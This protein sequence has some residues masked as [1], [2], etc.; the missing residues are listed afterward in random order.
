[1][2]VGNL[3]YVAGWY[4]KA[5]QFINQSKIKCAFVS[6]NSITQGQQVP[7]LWKYLMEEHNIVINFAYRTFNWNSEAKDKAAVHCVI[8]GFSQMNNRNKKIYVSDEQIELVN[9]INGYLIDSKNIF[10]S[11]R[12]TPI[13][14]IP[15]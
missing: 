9:N 2:G 11:S 15:K 3:D 6:T 12:T 4:G 7:I 5:V 14:D 8:I 13:S 10:I 1:K